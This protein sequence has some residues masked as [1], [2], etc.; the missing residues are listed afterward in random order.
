MRKAGRAVWLS[1]AIS[2]L[3][4]GLAIYGARVSPAEAPPARPAPA[5]LSAGRMFVLLPDGRVEISDAWSR[6]VFRWDG[7]RWNQTESLSQSRPE[8]R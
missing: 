2:L 5:S 1:L 8:S 6:R 3:A 7:H 4:M